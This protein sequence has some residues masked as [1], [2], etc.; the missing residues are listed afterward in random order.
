VIVEIIFVIFLK[1]RDYRIYTERKGGIIP[2]RC[3][4][5]RAPMCH[6]G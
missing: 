2:V 1:T 5:S 6:S 3:Y 4:N